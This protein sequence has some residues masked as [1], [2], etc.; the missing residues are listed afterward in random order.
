MKRD[1][2]P[3]ELERTLQIYERE[4]PDTRERHVAAVAD[5]YKAETC[6]LGGCGVVY[7]AHHH[8]T[9]CTVENCPFRDDQE[10]LLDRL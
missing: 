2:T 7:L 10:S 6:L 5:G 8:F 9:R 4:Y 1:A 3:E